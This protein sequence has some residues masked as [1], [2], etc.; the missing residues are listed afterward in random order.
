[1]KKQFG[2]TV[3]ELIIA[4]VILV[5]AGS[6]FA[7]QRADLSAQH[8][9]SDRKAAINAMYYNL[10]EVVYP[11]LGGYP[12]TLTAEQLKAMDSSLLKD[13]NGVSVGESGS[14]YSYE[15]SSCDGS[16]CKHYTLRASLE[17]EATYEKTSR[18]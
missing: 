16:L 11:S 4:I 14:D 7:I 17:R 10:E 8:R 1:M 15:P 5:T 13:P 2:F 6:I 3:L 9:D 12:L 18:H